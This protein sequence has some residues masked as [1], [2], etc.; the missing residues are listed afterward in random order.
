[1]PKEYIL[2]IDLNTPYANYLEYAEDPDTPRNILLRLA[3]HTYPKIRSAVASNQKISR[4]AFEIL[5]E[6]K[7][8]KVL[9]ALANNPAAPD[10][11]LY[12]LAKHE[13]DDVRVALA[14]NTSLPERAIDVLSNS[15]GIEVDKNLAANPNTPPHLL[16]EFFFRIYPDDRFDSWPIEA[17]LASNP[18]T[19]LDIL[20]QIALYSSTN[21]V[22]ENEV[23]TALAKNPSTPASVLNFLA[24]AS[25]QRAYYKE[26]QLAIINNPKTIKE[27][28][29]K[30]IVVTDLK[31]QEALEKRLGSDFD[32][33][34][35]KFDTTTKYRDIAKNSDTNP[36]TL[37]EIYFS[38][39]DN[40]ELNF[41]LASNP[42]TPEEVLIDLISRDIHVHRIVSNQGI[43]DKV[44][45]ALLDYP[46]S[47]N[48]LPKLLQN[49]SLPS[50]YI[51]DI[52]NNSKKGVYKGVYP[53]SLIDNYLARAENTPDEVLIDLAFE[54]AKE[55]SS[56][57]TT[58]PSL[59]LERENLPDKA[60]EYLSWI[61]QE[62]IK[63]S[64]LEHPK[65]PLSLKK[66]LIKPLLKDRD[67]FIKS[68][69]HLNFKGKLESPAKSKTNSDL[70]LLK[71]LKGLIS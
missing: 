14:G 41:H 31:V 43:T 16:R 11:I 39:K 15:Q 34:K 10:D 48:I 30:F 46:G 36:E 58:L 44:I 45:D 57:Y 18:N 64:I 17:C 66:K 62:H 53:K 47:R 6:D 29:Y 49:Q 12:N 52:Y 40:F 38:N 13:N 7:E 4:K 27:S 54:E 55:K 1:M 24:G 23:L 3:K 71:R 70:E 51:L 8:V 19:P 20:R 60:F 56:T 37:S 69:P 22:A 61:K 25:T 33:I 9:K 2:P 21:T 26:L 42:N 32:D 67:S 35:E 65:A 28:L 59:L 68:K 63:R 5:A 50:K